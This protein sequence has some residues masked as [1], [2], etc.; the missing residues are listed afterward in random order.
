MN[1]RQIEVFRAFMTTGTVAGAAAQLRVSQPGISRMLKHIETQLRLPLFVRL[2]GRL[3]P[4]P[5][6]QTLFEEVERAWDGVLRVQEAARG[7]AQSAPGVLRVIVSP[8]LGPQVIP[9]ALARLRQ[10]HPTLQYTFEMIPPAALVQGLLDSRADIGVMAGDLAHPALEARE[11]GR[12]R[13]VCIMPRGHALE[14]RRQV[15]PADLAA[16]PLVSF[17]R[18]TVE[19]RMIDDAFL[20]AGITREMAVQ[21]RSSSSAGWFVQSGI[22][23]ALVDETT[24]WGGTY[25]RLV[26]RPFVPAITLSIQVLTKRL[27]PPSLAMRHF[28]AAVETALTAKPDRGVG[29]VPG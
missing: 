12:S 22:G 11:V 29:A 25:P 26:T 15:R 3:L 21:V 10:A 23:L 16:W 14:A 20:A 1:L 28:A 18:D 19:G 27:V 9:M 7:L 17:A 2:Q 4:T 13:L 24:L 5:E 6:A 8:S